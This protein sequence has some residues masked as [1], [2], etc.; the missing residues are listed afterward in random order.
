MRC[1]LCQK[2]K[3]EIHSLEKVEGE[4]LQ[5]SICE[6]C[7]AGQHGSHAN[8][9]QLPP[10][11]SKIFQFFGQILA[12]SPQHK[13]PE[14]VGELLENWEPDAEAETERSCPGCGMSFERFQDLRRLGCAR[15]YEVFGAELEQLFRSV[16]GADHHVGKVPGRP[17]RA[18]PSSAE[19]GRLKEKLEN[20]IREERF[21]EAAR[22]RDKLRL[23]L[24]SA[25]ETGTGETP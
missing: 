13:V 11:A 23:L 8:P 7:A 14:T 12:A 24:E 15:C 5:Q 18:M 21:E 2:N 22:F 1:Q 20:A 9:G 4:W 10:G 25:G 19:I 3:A 6:Q 16:H 17:E